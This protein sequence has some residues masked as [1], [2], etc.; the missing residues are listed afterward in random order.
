MLQ[1][2][3][4]HSYTMKTNTFWRVCL[5]YTS[6]GS[7]NTKE[8]NA[9]PDNL[10][11]VEWNFKLWSQFSCHRPWS[12]GNLIKIERRKNTN[13]IYFD[14]SARRAPV[15]DTLG[16]KPNP[17]GAGGE[18]TCISGILLLFT[19]DS[20]EKEMREIFHSGWVINN[21]CCCLSTSFFSEK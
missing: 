17:L 1:G 15:K 19:L 2:T 12:V 8:N 21:F 13:T 6:G 20:I 18:Y 16:I 9:S 11:G 4:P 10:A 5:N 14:R 7:T 3:R